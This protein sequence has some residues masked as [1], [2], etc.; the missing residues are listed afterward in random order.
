MPK[1]ALNPAEEWRRQF[2]APVAL[3]RVAAESSDV[4]AVDVAAD[5]GHVGDQRPEQLVPGG[6]PSIGCR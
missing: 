4:V 3:V 1:S 5:R 6:D 2:D